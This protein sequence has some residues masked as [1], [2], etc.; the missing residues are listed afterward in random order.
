[1]RCTPGSRGRGGRSASGSRGCKGRDARA[2]FVLCRATTPARIAGCPATASQ[3]MEN[4]FQSIHGDGSVPSFRASH[5]VTDVFHALQGAA[6]AAAF[7]P[8]ALG[9]RL[10][11]VGHPPALP[12]PALGLL[13][14]PRPRHRTRT[15]RVSRVARRGIGPSA[16][17]VS[18]VCT[19]ALALA[20][21]HSMYLSSAYDTPTS[22]RAPLDTRLY[23]YKY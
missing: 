10:R 1:M 9:C 2:G 3:G 18:Y 7:A 12:P 4:R 6:T 13:F 15:S 14:A 16:M 17:N 8:S 20:S 23:I 21:P 11:Q 22:I 5:G 19:L